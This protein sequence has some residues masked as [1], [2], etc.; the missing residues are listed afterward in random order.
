MAPLN[1]HPA[2]RDRI[3]APHVA[4]ARQQRADVRFRHVGRSRNLAR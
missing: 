1:Q 4:C 2:D 3:V